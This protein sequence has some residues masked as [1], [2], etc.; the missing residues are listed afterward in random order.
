MAIRTW[1]E[2][3]GGMPK[4]MVMDA[5]LELGVRKDQRQASRQ[6]FHHSAV[7]TVGPGSY[8]LHG[9][10]RNVSASG[11]QIRLTQPLLPFTLV[12]VEY[13][14][15]LLLGEVVYCQQEQSAWQVGLRIEHGLFGLKT[16]ADAMPPHR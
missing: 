6:Q 8:I 9:E 14:D 7:V 3:H 15:N 13:D 10:I 1:K 4:E 11:T 16:L 2:Q 12:K 5:P